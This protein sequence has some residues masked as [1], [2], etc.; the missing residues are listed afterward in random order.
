MYGMKDPPK[1]G[2]SS[3]AGGAFLLE[4][5]DRGYKSIATPIPRII[6]TNTL[7]DIRHQNFSLRRYQGMFSSFKLHHHLD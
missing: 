1:A 2:P 3:S 4:E 6:A 5:L 7:E